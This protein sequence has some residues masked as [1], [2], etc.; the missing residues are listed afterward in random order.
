MVYARR[1]STDPAT[2]R[3]AAAVRKARHDA[4]ISL[5]TLCDMAELTSGSTIGYLE[6]GF[7]TTLETAAKL[8]VVLDINLDDIAHDRRSE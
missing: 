7:G 6:N 8:A 1:K 4:G 3:F 5:Q 2:Q